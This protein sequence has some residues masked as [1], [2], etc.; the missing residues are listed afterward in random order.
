MKVILKILSSR[1]L[2]FQNQQELSNGNSD[3][4]IAIKEDNGD[5]I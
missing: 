1:F 4:D 2:L 3:K 5:L